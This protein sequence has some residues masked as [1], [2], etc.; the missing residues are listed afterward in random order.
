MGSCTAGPRSGRDRPIAARQ[1]SRTYAAPWRS[2][3]CG[4]TGGSAERRARGDRA[5]GGHRPGAAALVVVPAGRA[6]EA[7]AGAAPCSVPVCR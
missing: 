7:V 3:L 5:A 2:V 4:V 1:R 6:A